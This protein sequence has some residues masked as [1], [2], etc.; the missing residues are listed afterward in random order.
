MKN[1][2]IGVLVGVVFT[3]A[4]LFYVGRVKNPVRSTSVAPV[5][6]PNVAASSVIEG[7]KRSLTTNPPAEVPAPATPTPA[8][9]ESQRPTSVADK[10]I[11]PEPPREKP[12]VVGLSERLKKGQELTS[13]D[14]DKLKH[15]IAAEAPELDVPEI[16]RDA[17]V[18]SARLLNK[19]GGKLYKFAGLILEINS[20]DVVIVIK[21]IELVCSFADQSWKSEGLKVNGYL[22]ACGSFESYKQEDDFKQISLANCYTVEN[23]YKLRTTPWTEAE[24]AQELRDF[25]ADTLYKLSR[26][27]GER[28]LRRGP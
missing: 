11:T 10:P 3:A 13:G 16:W 1:L 20:Y 6:K 12:A 9:E 7:D 17:E 21:N 25:Q 26:D 15:S 2:I 14:L 24:K 18:S 8:K 27:L 5:D 4:A 19:H 23:F 22:Y 28:K